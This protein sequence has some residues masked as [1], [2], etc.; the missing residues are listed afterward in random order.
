MLWFIVRSPQPVYTG[1]K[2][3]PGPDRSPQVMTSTRFLRACHRALLRLVPRRFH[4]RPMAAGA[5]V[6]SL[7]PAQRQEL[8]RNLRQ[9]LRP[10]MA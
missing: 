3:A 5:R 2:P 10:K 6:Q 1:D 8:A 9:M 7:T 4:T